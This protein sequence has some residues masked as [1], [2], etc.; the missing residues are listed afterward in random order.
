MRLPRTWWRWALA[1]L[2]AALF[3]YW[4]FAP[5]SIVV[6]V[7]LVTRGPLVVTVDEEGVTRV[8]DR[9]VVTASIS[10]RLSRIGPREGD[11]VRPGAR[12]ATL[13]PAPLDPRTR[14]EAGAR[15][16]A[17]LDAERT[18]RATLAQAKSALEQAEREL[19][20]LETLFRQRVIAVETKERAELTATG[21]RR[22]YEAAEFQAQ[23][24]AHQAEEA[25]ATLG[26]LGT[27][28]SRVPVVA[29]VGGRILRVLEPDERVLAAGTPILEVGDPRH[30][31]VVVD[32]L[33]TDA[34]AVGS[35]DTVRLTGWGGQDTL[36]ATVTRIE[37][38]GF[39]KISALGVEEQ[40]V[41]VI[42]EVQ[43]P[44][45]TLGDR[46]RVDASI[47]VWRRDGVTRVPRGALFRVG[48]E[49]RVFVA[50]GGRARERPV[51]IGRLGTELAEVSSGLA[52]GDRVVLRPDERISDGTRIRPREPPAP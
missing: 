33:S 4:A 34:V 16:E 20:R 43:D 3:L 32:L 27:S 45:P 28:S 40:R 10:G 1:G 35:G 47:V 50:A 25:R 6:D 31:E 21:R 44:P 9:F 29:P 22:E 42:G 19:T 13:A 5:S 49:W 17:A 12:I 24:A 18:A 14:Q 48:S 37:P 2:A 52:E 23:A 26:A 39:T 7:G 41:N 38:S 46:Y 51:A 15:Y 30:L 11:S 8:R 36:L